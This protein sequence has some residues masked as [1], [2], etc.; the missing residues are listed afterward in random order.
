MDGVQ[1]RYE[2]R[3]AKVKQM[4]QQGLTVYPYTYEVT[5][6][7]LEIQKKY[8][9]LEAHTH[10]EDKV[11][12]AGR[13]M[14]IRQMG[15]LCFAHIQDSSGKIQI[16]FKKDDLLEAFDRLQV[17]DIGD[18]LGIQGTIMTTKTGE[19][20]VHVQSWTMLCKALRDLPEKY[21]GLQNPEL[22]Y[23]QRH[24]DMIVNADV[25]E[26]FVKRAKIIQVIREVLTKRGF[27]EV[28]TPLLQT[29]Y[30]GANAKPFITHINAWDMRMYLSISPELY[31][32]RLLVGGFDKVYTICKNFRN[33]GVDYSHNPE[34]TMLEAYQSYVDYH[35]MMDIVEECYEQACLAVNGTTQVEVIV[36]HSNGEHEKRMIDFKRPWP[37]KTT[38][39]V[40]QEQLGIDVLSMSVEQL[41]TY[42]REQKLE[43]AQSWGACVMRI[44]DELIEHTI[45]EPTHVMDKPVEA[46]PLC[47][48]HRSDNRLVEQCE[49]IGV[50]MELGNIYSELNDPVVQKELL[51]QQASQLRGGDDE[52][53]PMDEDFV[54]AIEQ[55]MPPAGGLGIGIDRMVILLT[56][57][58]SIRDVI[59]FPTMKPKEE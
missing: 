43:P 46:T 5:H 14:T 57:Q 58:K 21:H 34:F 23:R 26:V 28:E 53:H 12:I 54:A 15:K 8:E 55:G 44:F 42:I 30:G 47:K 56:G 24:V 10:I 31:L 37:K 38:A 3:L 35:T 40:I 50:G 20:S 39:Q 18:I 52:A 41:Q 25:R 33:E 29:Q 19:L 7:A 59:L 9:G 6:T 16:V 17:V 4:Q 2:E 51:E 48:V 1:Q 45:I 36:H 49:P 32:K 27:L 22:R 11:S 13:L